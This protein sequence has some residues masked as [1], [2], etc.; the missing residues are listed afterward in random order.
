MKTRTLLLLAVASGLI[1]LVAGS[2]KLFLI[3]DDE[4]SPHLAIGASGTAGDMSVTVT[5]VDQVDGQTFV[6]VRL[7]GADD[8]DGASSWVLGVVGEQLRPLAPPSSIGPACS[9]TTAVV[10]VDCVLA[11]RT[12][13]SP[14]VLRYERAGQTLRWDIESPD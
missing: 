9:A 1:I 3:A 4:P 6:G 12:D 11:F 2:I 7:V 8:A 13:K 10:A 5:S 14:G